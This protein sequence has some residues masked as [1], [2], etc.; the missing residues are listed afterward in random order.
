MPETVITEDLD[1]AV[2]AVERMGRCIAKPLY[3][4]KARGMTQLEPG[5]K[6]REALTAYRAAGNPVLYLQKMIEIPG[7]DLGVSFLGGEYLATYARVRAGTGWSTS[8][9]AG[10]KYARAN[11]SQSVIDLAHRAQALFDLA[12]TCVDVVETADGPMVFEVSAFGGFRGL[13]EACDLDAAD[14]YVS[15][16]IEQ[17]RHG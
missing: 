16:V 10:G 7:Q 14:R 2:L 9:A 17:V 6:L 4:S 8:T 5:A 12:F 1:E 15:W 13:K 11:P 3:T